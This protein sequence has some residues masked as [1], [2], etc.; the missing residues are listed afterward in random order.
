MTTL[1]AAARPHAPTHSART[2]FD[3]TAA[4]AVLPP[5]SEPALSCPACGLPATVE[6]RD[7]TAGTSGPVVH[8]KVRCPRGR[9]WF[10]TTEEEL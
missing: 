9:H 7:M 5:A 8:L 10:L 2:H 6:S 1:L 4:P 3:I